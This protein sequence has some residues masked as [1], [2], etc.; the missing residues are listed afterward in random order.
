MRPFRGEV[1]GESE[2]GLDHVR[3]SVALDPLSVENAVQLGLNLYFVRHYDE[4]VAQIR[5]ALDLDPESPILF[6]TKPTPS[7]AALPRRSP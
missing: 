2:E 1:A 5:K 3:R 4:A 6:W 7:R